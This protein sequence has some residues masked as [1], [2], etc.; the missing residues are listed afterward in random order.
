MHSRVISIS[1]V[2]DACGRTLRTR[3]VIITCVTSGQTLKSR[4]LT[5]GGVPR[6]VIS[7]TIWI[8]PASFST[9]VGVMHQVNR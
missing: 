5:F 3:M 8:V 2:P 9:N 7:L 1:A 4:R 6:I